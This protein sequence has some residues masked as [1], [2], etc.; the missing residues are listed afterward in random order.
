MPVATNSSRSNGPE[1]LTR[2]LRPL[3]TSPA[4]TEPSR[5]LSGRRRSSRGGVLRSEAVFVGDT[6]PWSTLVELLRFFGC[7]GCGS[8][9]GR[10]SRSVAAVAVVL[11]AGEVKPR[12]RGGTSI[13]G[14]VPTPVAAPDKGSLCPLVR[15]RSMLSASSCTEF[16]STGP[17]NARWVLRKHASVALRICAGSRSQLGDSGSRRDG[18]PARARSE[19]AYAALR[20]WRRASRCCVSS[21]AGISRASI[22]TAAFTRTGRRAAPASPVESTRRRRPEARI[23]LGCT[24]WRHGGLERD[25]LVVRRSVRGRRCRLSAH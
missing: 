8:G 19:D 4:R 1:G 15:G 13:A 6:L 17:R 20:M 22:G 5:N 9:H 18:R 3:R 23:W 16:T 10:S 21:A 11:S 2:P 14:G 7:F 24:R 25:P 12:A